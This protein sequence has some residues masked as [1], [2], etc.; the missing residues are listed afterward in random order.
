MVDRFLNLTVN[1]IRKTHNEHYCVY[2]QINE[3]EE[4]VVI[5]VTFIREQREME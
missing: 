3:L 2:I 4:I 5:I 1:K